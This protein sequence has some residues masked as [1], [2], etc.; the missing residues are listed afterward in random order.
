MSD[1]CHSFLK[2]YSATFR[3]TMSEVMYDFA[4]SNI[5]RQSCICGLTSNILIKHLDHGQ[6]EPITI[7]KRIDKNCWGWMCLS[8]KE[9][10]KCCSG[11]Y[12]GM[13]TPT[14]SF[15]KFPNISLDDHERQ[16]RVRVYDHRNNKVWD[17]HTLEYIDLDEPQT[18]QEINNT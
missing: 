14:D 13:F 9:Y 11:L 10:P 2:T 15:L 4:R 3:K 6:S 18:L 17:P 1:A 16:K 7:D 8:C 12:N 5:Q